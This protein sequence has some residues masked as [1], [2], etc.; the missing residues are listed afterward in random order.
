MYLTDYQ[1]I[2]FRMMPILFSKRLN[3]GEYKFSAIQTFAKTR[4]HHRIYA[5]LSY[6][7]DYQV[8][9]LQKNIAFSRI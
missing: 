1:K 2:I 4:F 7:I 5:L 3:S 8:F 6:S 9:K